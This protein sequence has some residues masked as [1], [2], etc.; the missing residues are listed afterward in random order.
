MEYKVKVILFDKLLTTMLFRCRLMPPRP[1]PPLSG[2]SKHSH[3]SRRDARAL[4]AYPNVKKSRGTLNGTPGRI[5]PNCSNYDITRKIPS[6]FQTT[7]FTNWDTIFSKQRVKCKF[8]EDKVRLV[9]ES[10]IRD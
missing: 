3:T 7:V 8:E 2:S 10:T 4:F 5:E 9:T 1:R 6:A